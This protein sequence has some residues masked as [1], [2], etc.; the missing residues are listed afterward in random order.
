MA[1]TITLFDDGRLAEVVVGRAATAF[2]AM[3]LARLL[4]AHGI[5]AAK[6]IRHSEI[7]NPSDGGPRAPT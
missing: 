2:D 3:E 6:I 1:A 4:L 5:T 7:D